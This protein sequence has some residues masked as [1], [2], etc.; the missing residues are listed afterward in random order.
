MRGKP[1]TGTS[2]RIGVSLFDPP[3]AVGPDDFRNKSYIKALARS[4]LICDGLVSYCACVF[5]DGEKVC[6]V[7]MMVNDVVSF[8]V[9]PTEHGGF[10]VLWFCGVDKCQSFSNQNIFPITETARLPFSLPLASHRMASRYLTVYASQG[11]TSIQ[12]MALSLGHQNRLHCKHAKNGTDM[13]LEM[14]VRR[15]RIAGTEIPCTTASPDLLER[16]TW[17][18]PEPCFFRHPWRGQ[19]RGRLDYHIARKPPH[20]NLSPS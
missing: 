3:F 17:V 16:E 18:S 13:D 9:F 5:V 15:N 7:T 19:Q 10:W 20:T 8:K 12:C 4:G 11:L 14:E 1:A 2:T 6:G